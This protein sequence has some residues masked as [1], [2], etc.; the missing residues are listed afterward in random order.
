MIPAFIKCNSC[1]ARIEIHTYRKFAV[2]PYCQNHV[3]FHGFEYRSFNWN[4]GMYSDINEWTDCPVCRS[5][6][7]FLD[8]KHK[9][10]MCPD[11]NYVWP[12]KERKHGI[13]WFCDECDTYL[14]IQPGFSAKKKTWR[15]AECGF[16][17]SIT[18]DNVF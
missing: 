4:S 14:N 1:G 13:L 15:C 12:L 10:Y 17:N 7:M 9:S 2:C 18:K 8:S 16:T 6:N 5:P 3:P 11:C